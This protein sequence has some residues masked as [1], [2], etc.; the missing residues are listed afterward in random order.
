VAFNVQEEGEVNP[1]S[2]TK[3]LIGISSLTGHEERIS[4]FLGK[5]LKENGFQIKYIYSGPHRPNL[6]AF[7]GKPKI[8]F[9]SHLDTVPPYFP[10][11]ENKEVVYGRGAC[12][13]KGVI[14]AQIAAGL[15]LKKEGYPIGFLYLV[16][17]EVDHC[18]AID[19][20]KKIP[21]VDAI[22]VGEPTQNR[23]ALAA[24]GIVKIKL[25][26]KGKAAHSAYPSLGRSAV[27]PLLKTLILMQRL[28]LP[29]TKEMGMSS[30]NI[31]LIRGGS[32][33]NII[34]EEAEAEILVRTVTKSRGIFE[35]LKGASQKGVRIAL[36]SINDPIRL[37]RVKG[38]KTTVVSF[39]TDIAYLKTKA[40]KIFLLGPGSI[41]NAHGP[42]EKI[43]KKEIFKAVELY[44]R[45]VLLFKK[46]PE[47]KNRQ[48]S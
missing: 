42:H 28:K 45:M 32:A 6:F 24:K 26:S 7:I 48:S 29:K 31:G 11:R 25:I 3:E 21:N 41:L 17:E 8:L 15:K 4:K 10:P 9:C 37:D 47:Y 5:L 23:M 27:E 46:L 12:D 38:F 20:S 19:V 44:E 34:P 2:L 40:K 39:N 43:S 13:A 22:I 30:L 16:G 1:I 14:A 18:G 36:Q 33:A 35:R